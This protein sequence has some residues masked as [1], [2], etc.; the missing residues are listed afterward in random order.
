MFGLVNVKIEILN[1]FFLM[2]IGCGNIV[3]VLL[4]SIFYKFISNL[5]K[6]NNIIWIN[7][8]LK[9]NRLFFIYEDL[10]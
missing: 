1:V 7:L 3:Y 4:E 5:D 6:E 2:E 8:E 9:K 10:G